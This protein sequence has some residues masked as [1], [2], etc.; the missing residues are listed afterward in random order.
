VLVVTPCPFI[1]EFLEVD[2]ELQ[3]GAQ[4]GHTAI[5]TYRQTL[6]SGREEGL[7][8]VTRDLISGQ[9]AN[10]QPFDAIMLANRQPASSDAV[11]EALHA[12]PQLLRPGGVLLISAPL[13]PAADASAPF[14]QQL[15]WAAAAGYSVI[16]ADQVD[17]GDERTRTIGV[18]ALQLGSQP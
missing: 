15:S 3:I 16:R 9:Q 2:A 4:L 1:N 5:N 14:E 13:H 10:F 18:A 8:T 12:S 11:Q 6:Y 17:S 7:Q